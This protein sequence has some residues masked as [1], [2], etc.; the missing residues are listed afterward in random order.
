M[1][2][3]RAM[4]FLQTTCHLGGDVRF[5]SI[6]L[7]RT[8]VSLVK[9]LVLVSVTFLLLI[10]D[11]KNNEISWTIEDM[12]GAFSGLDKLRRLT[13]Q[14]NRIRSITK[15]AFSGLDAL[16]HL[17]PVTPTPS[18]ALDV[19]AFRDLSDNAIMSLQGNAFSQM[20]KLQQL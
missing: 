9:S 10:R 11:L 7:K 12:N 2:W 3:G 4:N 18:N 8:P 1:T 16:E 13:L 17:R 19:V 14:G 15:K 5:L 6:S 20:K